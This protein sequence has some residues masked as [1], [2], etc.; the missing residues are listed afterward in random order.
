M[1]A[2]LPRFRGR[3]DRRS[4]AVASALRG[5]AIGGIPAEERAWIDRI[6]AHRGRLPSEVVAVSS[7][8]S[9][10]GRASRAD[11]P[12]EAT[13]AC[14]WMSIPAVSGR[15]LM[16]LVRLLAPRSC[17][18][19]GTGFGVSTAYQ[20]AALEL[21]GKGTMTSLDLA[22]MTDIAGPGLARLGLAGRTH[23]VPGRIE[24]T[25]PAVLEAARPI[26][27]AFLDA[28]HTPRGTLHPLEVMIPHLST[29]AVV[30]FDD[31]NW[32]PGMRVTWRRIGQLPAVV[33]A[34]RIHRL[35]VTVVDA[36]RRVPQ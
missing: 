29:G 22:G 13:K 19:L 26:D 17:L 33:A 23:L 12:A 35:G 27:F 34:Y 8:R 5:A 1:A 32:T 25:L 36:S 21:N 16:R 10:H 18:E 24:R 2:A 3:S 31:I 11:H 20:A 4:R 28:D 9:P 30:V 15:F 7:G 14:E 6:E